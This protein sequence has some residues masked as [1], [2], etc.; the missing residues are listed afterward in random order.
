MH[1]VLLAGQPS[2]TAYLDALGYAGAPPRLV[3]APK[4]APAAAQLASEAERWR[5]PY[6]AVADATDA[7]LLDRL[8]A[9]EPDLVLLA[10]WPDAAR[11][12]LRAVAR[13]AT[14]EV[15]AACPPDHRAKEPLFWAILN[16][17]RRVRLEVRHATHE[18]DGGPVVWSIDVGVAPDATSASL[19][20]EVDTAGAR[21]VS[22][23]LAAARA[24]AIPRGEH[25][26]RAGRRLPPLRPEHG[27]ID[28]TRPAVELERLV[29]AATGE[30]LPYLF[31]RGVKVGVLRADVVP[32][33]R[34]ASPGQVVAVE[35]GVAFATADSALRIR[36][37]LFLNK[38]YAGESLARELGI[39]IGA[40]MSNS[41]AF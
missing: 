14:L 13:L 35:N 16:D 39:D 1:V 34:R 36:R 33:P 8:R 32:A 3:V 26:P 37:A 19:A 23:I 29:R 22:E 5:V 31:Y 15:H 17:H 6:V 40:Q 18:L 10:G 12:P 41:P 2:S 9:S 20:H 24:G 30:I 28:L 7:A 21:L 38:S 11:A 25:I 27:L 4:F